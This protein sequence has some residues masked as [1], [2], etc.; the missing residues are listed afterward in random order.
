MIGANGMS[1]VTQTSRTT[2]PRNRRLPP[3]G[4]LLAFAGAAAAI[5]GSFLPWAAVTVVR[6]PVVGSSISLSP[7]GWNGDGNVVVGLG[8]LAVAI[9][10]LLTYRDSG[11]RGAILRTLLLVFGLAIVAVTF[12]DTTHV[13]SRFSH[14]A[15][16]IEQERQA[17]RVAP[18]VR[19]RV[20]PGIVIAAG[21]GVILV[22]AAVIDRFLFDEEIIEEED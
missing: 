5:G 16:R 6:N 4:A 21:G 17:T 20:S 14:V 18:R 3:V 8:I 2:Q 22:F 15:D 10:G 11:R 9:G 12:W 19:T 13:S 7:Q 1:V